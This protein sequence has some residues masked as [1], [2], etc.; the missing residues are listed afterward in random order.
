MNILFAYCSCLICKY[1]FYKIYFGLFSNRQIDGLND[2]TSKP[3]I[4]LSNVELVMQTCFHGCVSFCAEVRCCCFHVT[5]STLT[6]SRDSTY[7]YLLQ[8]SLD[9]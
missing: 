4:E 1:F 9:Y 7:Y 2:A 8:G 6:Q 3:K 5:K